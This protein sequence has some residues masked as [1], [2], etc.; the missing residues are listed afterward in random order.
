MQVEEYIVD[1]IRTEMGL[2]QQNIWIQSQNRKIPPESQELYCVVGVTNFRPISSKSKFLSTDNNEQQIVYGRA[3]VQVDLMSRSN[4][5]RNRRSEVL[6]ALNSFY[7]KEQQDSKC[8]RIFEL[9]TAFINTSGLQGGSD[10]NRFTLIIPTMISEV[11][12]KSA[13]YYDKFRATLQTERGVFAK[14]NIEPYTF[15]INPVPDDASVLIN[16]QATKSIQLPAMSNIDWLVSKTGYIS[17]QG[18]FTLTQDTAI[19]VVLQ[20]YVSQYTLTVNPVPATAKVLLNGIERKSITVF[21]GSTVSYQ[22]SAPGYITQSGSVVVNEDQEL[23]VELIKTWTFTINATPSDAVVMINDE[24]VSSVT[25]PEGALVKWSVSKEGY[26]MQEGQQNVFENVILDIELVLVPKQYTLTIVPTPSNA[27]VVMNGQETTSITVDEGTSVTYEVSLEGYETVTDTVVVNEPTEISVVLELV[28][29]TFTINPTPENALVKINGVEQRSITAVGG[30]NVTYEVSADGYEPKSGNHVIT[31][32]YTLDITLEKL[33]T[34]TINPNP[35]DSVV[36]M[37]EQLTNS[38]IGKAGTVVQWSVSKP[39]YVEQEGTETITSDKT[40]DIVLAEITKYTFTINP[41]PADAIVTIN[42]EVR[43]SITAEENTLITWSVEAEGYISQSGEYTLTENYTLAVVLEENVPV[44]EDYTIPAA[45]G[46]TWGGGFSCGSNHAVTSSNPIYY[47]FD[48]KSSTFC[49]WSK[50]SVGDT[51]DIWIKFPFPL[52]I[53]SLGPSWKYT[54]ANTHKWFTIDEAGGETLLTSKQ[55]FSIPKEDA[56]ECWG[57][58]FQFVA[59]STTLGI[60]Q[61]MVSSQKEA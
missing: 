11:K 5:A 35:E 17:Q 23:D 18:N 39:G 25:V 57:V 60:I 26:R 58:K 8:F 16:N 34:F 32:D 31:G 12:I 24:P 33:Y 48:E 14:A 9:P 49:R 45:T 4:E 7:S 27:K 42:G 21:E 1:I 29:Y 36:S 6:M 50:I 51:I 54:G 59:T 28:S 47:A 15:S 52:K 3:D 20:E 53:Y 40:L 46:A 41:T 13:A 22:V 19:D 61:I 43:N 2:S 10:I 55:Y 56:V 44:W 30:T 38:V 37:N